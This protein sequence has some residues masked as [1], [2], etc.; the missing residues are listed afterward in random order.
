MRYTARIRKRAKATVFGS[1]ITLMVFM[2]GPFFTEAGT[3]NALLSDIGAGKIRWAYYVAYDPTSYESIKTNMKNLDYV[4]PYWYHMDG[5]GNLITDASVAD[6][7]KESVIT[8]ARR[9]GVK[10]VPMVKNTATYSDFHA[11]LTDT[12]VRSKAVQNLVDM[13]LSGNFDGVHVDFEGMDSADRNGLTAFMSELYGALSPRGKLVTQAVAAKDMERTTGWAGPYDYAA[14]GKYNDL[15]VIM[16]YGYGTGKPQST[17][18]FPWVEGS[19]AF[20]TSQVPAHKVLLGL[21]WYGYDWNTTAGTFKSVDYPDV[22]DLVNKYKPSVIYDANVETPNFKY[23]ADGQEHEVWY[24]DRRSNEA[25]VALVQKYGMAGAASWRIGHEDPGVWSALNDRLGYRTWF[26]AE[27]ATTSPFHTW[28][29]LMNPNSYTVNAKVTFMKE[30]GETVVKQYKLSPT[31]RLNIFANQEVPNSAFSTKVEADGP[32][33]VERA[34][35][36]GQDGH[37]S[38]GV[39]GPSHT[40]Y[41]PEGSSLPNADTWVLVMNPNSHNARVK[42]TFITTGGTRKEKEYIMSPTS[43]LNILADYEVP[44]TTF[45][46]I[47]ESDSPVIAERS[48]YFNDGAGGTGSPG[49]PYASKKWYLAEGFTGH[50]TSLALMNPYQADVTVKLTFMLEGSAPVTRQISMG[51]LSRQN[52][53]VNNILPPNTAFSTLVE[54]SSPIA[55][56][57]TSTWNNGVYGHSSLALPTPGRVWY[58]PE[59]STAPPFHD[60]ILLMNPNPQS[61]KAVVTFMTEKG[62]AVVREYNLAS[63]SRF[64]IYANWEVPN[65]ALSAKVESELPIM[66]ERAMYFGEGGTGNYGV[67]Q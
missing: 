26:L 28:V 16:T 36:F 14:L 42:V 43:R 56:E 18:P 30:S 23:A 52:V 12:A 7:N 39:N 66:V 13:A 59:G 38:S 64:T 49:T 31:S 33:F 6:K 55:V 3:Q 44:N 32:I 54:S 47:V 19:A 48:T 22:V 37:V 29:L 10:I 11:V 58:L 53:I 67:G 8:L 4:S 45:S 50:N 5:A 46:T 57:R 20:I 24:E 17:A 63:N 9:N 62:Q 51:P 25:K 34:M 21:A 60:Y 40:W 1:L 35:Y 2:L 65:T 41:L 15:I 27:G 61:A